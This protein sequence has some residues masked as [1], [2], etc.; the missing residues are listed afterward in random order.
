[1]SNA[2]SV[3]FHQE[4]MSKVPFFKQH[5]LQM[6]E[7]LGSVKFSIIATDDGFP[8]AHTLGDEKEAARKAAMAASLDGLCNSVAQE[9]ELKTA[10]AT[11]IETEDGLVFCRHVPLAPKKHVILLTATSIDSN[12]GTT[13]WGIKKTITEI[14]EGY[15][16]A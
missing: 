16:A 10:N 9:S 6:S 14:I 7:E 11:T 15:Q 8:V 4:V 5:L 1:M 3:L 2:E 13:L 12:Y